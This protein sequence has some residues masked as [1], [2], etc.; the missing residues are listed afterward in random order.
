MYLGKHSV[1][2]YDELRIFGE[3]G[4]KYLS[5][6][7]YYD[8]YKALAVDNIADRPPLPAEWNLF[9]E[10]KGDWRAEGSITPEM[11]KDFDV[12][13]YMHE[14]TSDQPRIAKNWENIKHKTVVYRSIG[15]S[16]RVTEKALAPC[17]AEGLKIVRYSP[18]ESTIPHYCGEDAIIRFGKDPEEFKDWNGDTK[19][20]ITV[21]QSMKM[22]GSACNFDAFTKITEPFERRLF[23][24]GNEGCGVLGGKLSFEDL[25]KEYR[26]NRVFLF[27]NTQ[28]ASYTLGFLEAFMTGIPI[29]AL[30]PKFCNRD[31]PEQKTYEVHEIIENGVNGFWSDDIKKLQE[32]ISLLLR[33]KELATRIGAAGRETAIKLFGKE[34]I[35][36][37]WGSFLENL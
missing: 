10:Y 26:D 30:G 9:D 37:Q 33:N 19:R 23:G 2:E 1:L 24:I 12:L 29:V 16:I 27:C 4:H 25:K 32:Y 17:K 20:V 36:A 8:P 5:L 7:M 14:P 31:Y 6:G 28:P 15:Q 35:K 21:G 3:L 18:K 13:I 22:R 11:I 34:K